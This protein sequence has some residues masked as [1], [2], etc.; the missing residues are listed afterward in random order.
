M[1]YFCFLAEGVTLFF[2]SWPVILGFKFLLYAV[3][4]ERLCKD[5]VDLPLD[6]FFVGSSSSISPISSFL[7]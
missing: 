6:C 3:L 5:F 4:L 2:F 7:P 1:D